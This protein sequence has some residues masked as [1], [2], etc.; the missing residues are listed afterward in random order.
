MAKIKPFRGIRYNLD[1]VKIG[2]VVVPPYD[3]ISDP[4]EYKDVYSFVNINLNVSHKKAAILLRKWIREGILKKDDDECIYIYNQTFGSFSRT[5]FIALVELEEL[6]KG[7]LPHEKTLA[8]PLADRLE[9]MK[10]TKCQNGKI[11]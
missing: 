11:Y 1:R 4:K 8:R 2:S 7:I 9:L 3:V 6:G 5:A 10:F